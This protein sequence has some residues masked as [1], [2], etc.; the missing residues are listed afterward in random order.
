MKCTDYVYVKDVWGWQ[1][2]CLMMAPETKQEEY[3][4]S[5]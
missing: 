4:P 2:V 1:D 5:F 3:K